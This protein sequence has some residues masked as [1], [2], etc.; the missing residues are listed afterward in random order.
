MVGRPALDGKRGDKLL[1]FSK[2]LYAEAVLD[3]HLPIH[4]H[5][6]FNPEVTRRLITT[7]PRCL[8]TQKMSRFRRNS[9]SSSV[10]CG[11]AA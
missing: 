7:P 4:V 5:F 8:S 1:H 10:R 2:T 9:S 6:F 11:S 3:S